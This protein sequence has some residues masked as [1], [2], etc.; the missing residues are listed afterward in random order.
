MVTDSKGV[1]VYVSR[2]R[3][4][5]DEQPLV[6]VW[7][8]VSKAR[9]WIE[10]RVTRKVKWEKDTTRDYAMTATADGSLVGRIRKTEIMDPA[11]LAMKYPD[12]LPGYR[13]IADENPVI[14]SI[15]RD[16]ERLTGERQ[17]AKTD[18][19]DR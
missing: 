2:S 1:E 4:A 15:A 7:A 13:R 8:D 6:A 12:H 9:S 11:G 5:T 17:R 10:S 19:A 3:T 14:P 16:D 18:V